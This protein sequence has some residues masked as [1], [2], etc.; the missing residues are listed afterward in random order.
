MNIIGLIIND[1]QVVREGGEGS[2]CYNNIIPL[3]RTL[4]GP[5]EC[6]LRMGICLIG[7]DTLGYVLHSRILSHETRLSYPF[8]YIKISI[9]RK[10][11]LFLLLI[12]AGIVNILNIIYIICFHYSKKC[13]VCW[14]K[15]RYN[16][17]AIF[18]NWL[19]A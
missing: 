17:N 13:I 14:K 8:W 2:R 9:H 5:R 15:N 19:Y 1:G 12:A 6:T 3:P 10:L 7:F 4:G 16:G 11:F 18:S